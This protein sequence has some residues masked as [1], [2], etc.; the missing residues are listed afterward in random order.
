M[1][2]MLLGLLTLVAGTTSTSILHCP[3]G[4]AECIASLTSESEQLK[5]NL[6]Q[7]R[8]EHQRATIS[9]LNND[10]GAAADQVLAGHETVLDQFDEDVQLRAKVAKRAA[11]DEAS[12]IKEHWIQENCCQE[13]LKYYAHT[14]HLAYV[15][16][17]KN[18][19]NTI[20]AALGLESGHGHCTALAFQ[21]CD[22]QVG[23]PI[24]YFTS[25][26]NPFERFV[27]AYF[28][29]VKARELNVEEYTWTKY[30]EDAQETL[31]SWDKARASD[32]VD[33]L[34]Y[35]IGENRQTDCIVGKDGEVIVQYFVAVESLN[36]EWKKLQETF[37][38]LPLF[39]P[40][41][42]AKNVNDYGDWCAY[43]NVDLS[44]KVLS[45]YAKDFS[46]LNYS[47]DLSRYCPMKALQ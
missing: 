5:V 43:Y 22:D 33:H 23:Q 40:P 32:Q 13:S 46:F 18:A 38:Q 4:D 35:C 34:S 27:S 30:V 26:R 25:V 19:G 1:M 36:E 24:P 14:Y 20:E 2:A 17:P 9:E 15:H 42:E 6:L 3:D 7:K 11:D 44:E 29:H 16:I 37:P 28:E 41:E 21:K 10:K 12:L 8:I 39:P 45:L 47:R 31:K